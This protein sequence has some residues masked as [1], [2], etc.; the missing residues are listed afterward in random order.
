MPEKSRRKDAVNMYIFIKYKRTGCFKNIILLKR[1]K[2]SVLLYYN[3]YVQPA[4][5]IPA[6]TISNRSPG[7]TANR[8]EPKPLK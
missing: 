5:M 4:S 1:R 8:Y 7:S 3:P 2:A 6:V